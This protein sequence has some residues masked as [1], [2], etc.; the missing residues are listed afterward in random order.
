[1]QLIPAQT[2]WWGYEAAMRLLADHSQVY[3]VDLC[4]QGRSTRYLL[5]VDQMMRAQDPCCR[6]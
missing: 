2:V 4:G 1:M 5:I 3:V 6:I